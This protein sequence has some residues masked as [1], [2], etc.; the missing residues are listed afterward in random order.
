MLG[1]FSSF[2]SEI[3]LMAV[4]GTPSVSLWKRWAVGYPVPQLDLATWQGAVSLFPNTMP[5]SGPSGRPHMGHPRFGL[6]QSMSWGE[7]E[8]WGWLGM[9]Q[10]WGAVHY[11]CPSAVTPLSAETAQGH[12]RGLGLSFYVF[13]PHPS[14][15]CW[16]LSL[17]RPQHRTA[18]G[19]AAS[20]HGGC[21][22]GPGLW[23]QGWALTV[24]V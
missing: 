10:S 20:Q 14:Q 1:C 21:L 17:T 22:P 3:S 6:E 24:L 12:P 16:V 4:L 11:G 23:C 7:M 8:L 2:S 9:G 5:Y 13:G 19:G 15:L 18:E